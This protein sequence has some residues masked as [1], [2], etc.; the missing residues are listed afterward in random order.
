MSPRKTIN[1]SQLRAMVNEQNRTSIC[2]PAIREGWNS[3]LEDILMMTQNY[4]GFTY[5]CE[6]EVPHGQLPGQRETQ[7]G[8]VLQ[9]PDES[10]RCYG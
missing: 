1:V 9:F 8:A 2:L 6:H 4:R 5:L 3:F 10:R 7:N